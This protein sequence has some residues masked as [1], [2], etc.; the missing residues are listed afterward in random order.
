MDN[1]RPLIFISNDDSV[2]APG[3]K[4]LIEIARNY[5]DVFVAAP[6]TP[7]SGKSSSITMDQP[8][9]ARL[10]SKEDGL[11][12]Y[13]INGTPVD[14]TK[15][16]FNELVPRLPDFVLSGMNHGYNYGNCVTYSGTMGVVFEASFYG[17]PSMGFSF[18]SHDWKADLSA[19]VPYIHQGIQLLMNN[20]FDRGICFN[21][22]IPTCENILGLRPAIH[23]HGRW[24]HE[25]EK[26]IDPF[27]R[28]YYWTVGTFV[29]DDLDNPLNDVGLLENGYAT[30]APCT[31]EQT[32]HDTLPLLYEILNK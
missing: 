2:N 32:H 18:G 14:C 28:P 29:V 22:N 17:I 30:I 25:F 20:N 19:C 31:A 7:Q 16:A 6:E 8:L 27:G 3:I 24:M 1:K 26:R 5:G 13:A 9:R 10:I 21:L 12:V 11:T 4:L 15:L 23:A